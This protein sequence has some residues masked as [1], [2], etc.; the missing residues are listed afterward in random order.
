MLC[1]CHV[2]LFESQHNSEYYFIVQ[3]SIAQNYSMLYYIVNNISIVY[4]KQKSIVMLFNAGMLN[5]ILW[6]QYIVQYIILFNTI[7]FIVKQKK[8][9]L[10]FIEKWPTIYWQYDIEHPWFNVKR[11]IVYG[12]NIVE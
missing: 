7:L 3:R 2:F 9:V 1:S 10:L 12:Q 5:N 6:S 11:F 8:I 4:W